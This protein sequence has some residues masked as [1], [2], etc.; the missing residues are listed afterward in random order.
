[1][2]DFGA[3]PPELDSPSLPLA[4]PLP[5]WLKAGLALAFGALTAVGIE[6]LSG[7][8]AAR[9]D[10]LVLSAGVASLFT[11]FLWFLVLG[12]R[13]SVG[14]GVAMLVPYVNLIAIGIYSRRFWSEDGRFPSLLA[15]AGSLL[16]TVGIVRL[17]LFNPGYPAV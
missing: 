6:A 17:L 10:L 8:G 11:S 16:Q 9:L 4:R 12:L 2:P 7:F 13:R 3:S 14:W 5:D 1:M 15:I